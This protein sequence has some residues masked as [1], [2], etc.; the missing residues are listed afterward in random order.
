M[1]TGLPSIGPSVTPTLQ[2]TM[3][4]SAYFFYDIS[5]FFYDISGGMADGEPAK[6]CWDLRPDI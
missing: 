4:P 3:W 5:Y 6:G 1:L 2:P